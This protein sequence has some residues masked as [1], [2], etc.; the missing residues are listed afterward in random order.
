MSLVTVIGLKLQNALRFNRVVYQP[1]RIKA[2]GAGC[3]EVIMQI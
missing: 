2:I 3:V 1:D